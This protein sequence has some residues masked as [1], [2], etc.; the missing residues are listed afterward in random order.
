MKTGHILWISHGKKKRVV[1]E[2]IDHVGLEWMDHVE[3]IACEMNSVFQ[4]A[5]EAKCPHIQSVFD[6]FHIV[7]SF[8]DKVVS[9][10]RKDEQQRLANEGNAAAAR[11][12][13]RTKYILTSSRATL[14]RKDQE[15]RDGKVTSRASQLFNK[16][17]TTRKEGYIAKYED[18]LQQSSCLQLTW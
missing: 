15:A 5:F 3:A 18:L 6:Y 1:Y 13:K 7:K 2:F 8:N 9:Q 10:I 17:E 12:L 16:D 14:E 11:A 4:E